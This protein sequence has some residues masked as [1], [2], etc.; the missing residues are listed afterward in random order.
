MISGQVAPSAAHAALAAHEARYAGE[1]LIVT[2]N[3]D[4][5]HERA[6]S[7][8]LIHMHGEILKARCGKCDWIGEW[9]G[10]M[11]SN[12]S[13]PDC[14]K[15][16]ALRSQVVWFGETSLEMDGIVEAL[17][18]CGLF[19]AIGTSGA[20]YPAAEFVADIRDRAHTVDLNLEPSLV[21]SHFGEAIYGKATD[22]VPAFIDRILKERW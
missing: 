14:G 5:L 12:N 18:R 19:V 2:Q 21:R 8:N 7:R 10:D 6:G 16:G 9:R 20:V 1:V 22:I 4:N 17:E 3:V 11:A 13:C 15:T